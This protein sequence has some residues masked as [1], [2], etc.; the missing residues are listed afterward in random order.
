MFSS[1]FEQQKVSISIPDSAQ[2]IFVS[3]M[4]CSDYVGGAELTTD[5]L[6]NSSP[7]EVFRLHAKDVTN[8]LLSDGISKFWIFGNFSSMN[9]DLMPAIIANIN[10]S[11]LEYDY[12]YCKYRSPEKHFAA[13]NSNCDCHNLM[14]GKMMVLEVLLMQMYQKVRKLQNKLNL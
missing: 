13:E 3:D 5:A 10:Y 4:F 8:D 12:K 7:Y 2:I 14:H 1:P 11:I 9:F 6:I